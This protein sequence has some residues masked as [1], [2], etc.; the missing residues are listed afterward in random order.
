MVHEHTNLTHALKEGELVSIKDVE[1]GLKCGCT[2]PACGEE[3]I[4]RKGNIKIHHFAH[5]SGTNCEFGYET[6]L[7]LMAKD[8]LSK[9][10]EIKLPEVILT[11]DSGKKPILLSE[12]KTIPID[13][14]ELEKK[15]DDIIPDIV[16]YSGEKKLFVEIFVTHKVDDIKIEKVKNANI[17]M[18]EINLRKKK[19]IVTYEEL[20]KILIENLEEKKW[21]HNAMIVKYFNILKSVALIMD[22]EN[23]QCPKEKINM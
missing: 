19:N 15:F 4:A 16:V 14:V 6:S 17:S 2:C 5:T 22:E 20:Q 1:S 7:H 3:L 8:I 11:F 10:K 13:R 23:V 9:A 12:A 18:I 21:I